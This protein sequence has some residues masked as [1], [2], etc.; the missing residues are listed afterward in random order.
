MIGIV[1]LSK[2]TRWL[3]MEL[4]KVANYLYLFDGAENK[5]ISDEDTLKGF[6]MRSFSTS[7]S[8][9]SLARTGRR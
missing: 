7:S 2:L 5:T 8:R 9:G 4:K 3:A 6:V 1:V